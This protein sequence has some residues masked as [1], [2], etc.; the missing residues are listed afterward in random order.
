MC[1]YIP[2]SLPP[3]FLNLQVAI[4]IHPTAK[5]T[6]KNR[7]EKE[8]PLRRGFMPDATPATRRYNPALSQTINAL[9]PPPSPMKTRWPFL[10][11]R[12]S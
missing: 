10:A 9:D 1:I 5:G 6:K 7:R 11:R 3:L 12:K 2:L 8:G 4:V